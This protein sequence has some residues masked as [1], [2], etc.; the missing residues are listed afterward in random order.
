MYNRMSSPQLIYTL[1]EVGSQGLG[2]TGR[3]LGSSQP[4]DGN[5]Q[6]KASTHLH[7]V[8]LDQQKNNSFIIGRALLSITQDEGS[9]RCVP[10]PWG[11]RVAMH[12]F[13]VAEI[14]LR[15]LWKYTTNV[16][17]VRLLLATSQPKPQ[18]RA[19]VLQKRCGPWPCPPWSWPCARTVACAWPCARWR[20]S[21]RAL[22]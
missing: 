6:R 8:S 15:Y 17:S 16:R 11:E 9:F 19:L 4:D 13:W 22:V 14:G 2:T 21:L 20:R 10:H 3:E 18:Q 7:A 1:R 12:R 5:T